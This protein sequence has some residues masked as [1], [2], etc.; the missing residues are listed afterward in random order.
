MGFL[1]AFQS[2]DQPQQP[3]RFTRLANLFAQQQIGA[4]RAG[5]VMSKPDDTWK[6]DNE[7][8]GGHA[9]E[10]PMVSPDDLIGTGI[11]SRIGGALAAA[12]KGVAAK[13]GLLG[14]IPMAGMLKTRVGRI[15]ENAAD[16]SSLA[17]M[18]QRAGENAGYVV[19]RS[20]SA[21]SP[22]KY[23]SF[24]KAGDDLRETTRQVRISNHADKYPELADGIRTSS[25]PET[26]VSF[27]QS[28]N[29]LASEGFPTR[30]STRYKDIPSWEQYYENKRIADAQPDK[31]LDRLLSWWS[32]QPKSSRGNPPTIEDVKNGVTVL[33]L[34]RR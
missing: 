27:E 32:N 30:L 8:I 6:P 20:D 28:V 17:D 15:A 4:D 31:K 22:S 34:M 2:V 16:S 10:A 33:D 14:A 29:W 5:S 25:D 24:T 12:A 3:E 19:T 7:R 13:G 26:G 11:P 18:L 1:D 21:I 23:V 9:L